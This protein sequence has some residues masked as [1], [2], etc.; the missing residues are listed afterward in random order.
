VRLYLSSILQDESGGS[1]DDAASAGLQT[2][3]ARVKVESGVQ[4]AKLSPIARLVVT[5]LS[6]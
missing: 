6:T 3:S 4:K 5:V 1:S 2:Y